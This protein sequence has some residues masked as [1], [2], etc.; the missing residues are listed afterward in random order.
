VGNVCCACGCGRS[1]GTS[2]TTGLPNKYAP[3]HTS[4]TY[5]TE[6]LRVAARRAVDRKRDAIRNSTDDRKSFF[7]QKNKRRKGYHDRYNASLYGR[8][9]AQKSAS[10]ARGIPFK[11]TFNEWVT[12]W[13][14]SGH[15][16]ERGRTGYVMARH[17]DVGAYETGNV[18]IIT[19][20]QNSRDIH[21]NRRQ[22][23]L[24]CAR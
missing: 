17:G 14:Q 16:N 23:T 19:A 8:F 21:L 15:L 3:G 20:S 10:R 24:E 22:K 11:L 1:T 12:I 13:T 6:A 4:R 2:V 5:A 9:S 7:R 18:S